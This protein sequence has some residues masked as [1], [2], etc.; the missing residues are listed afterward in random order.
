MIKKLDIA[1]SSWEGKQR[2]LDDKT[3]VVLKRL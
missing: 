1:I 3:I 2:A